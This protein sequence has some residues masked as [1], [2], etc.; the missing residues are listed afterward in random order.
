[1]ATPWQHERQGAC[2]HSNVNGVGQGSRV[3]TRC[4]PIGCEARLNTI[5]CLDCDNAIIG[6]AMAE[7]KEANQWGPFL[8][9]WFALSL[10]LNISG[11]SSIVDGFVHWVGFFRDALDIYR[12]WIREPLSLVA[13]LVWPLGWPKIPGWVFDLFVILSTFFL[14]GNIVSY[15]VGGHSLVADATKKNGVI[16]GIFTVV[17]WYFFLPLLG[18]LFLLLEPNDAVG[19]RSAVKF[20]AYFFLI[21]AIVIV[22]AF[23]NWQFQHR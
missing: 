13:H 9:F 2:D 7:A 23:L 15:Q 14:A 11:I 20:Y 19:R 8:Y 5:I 12:G 10:L 18:L 21:I 1:V 4:A 3:E 17:V 16:V 22:L 6:G